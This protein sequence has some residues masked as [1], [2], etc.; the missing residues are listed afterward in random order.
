MTIVDSCNLHNAEVVADTQDLRKKL[1]WIRE[2]NGLGRGV[3]MRHC[4]KTKEKQLLD[5]NRKTAK[6]SR[7]DKNQKIAEKA[8][9]GNSLPKP[10]ILTRRRS[11]N[12]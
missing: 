10:E 5:E 1:A 3:T 8:K 9:S 6:E 2:R 11:N 12:S 4:E 7:S